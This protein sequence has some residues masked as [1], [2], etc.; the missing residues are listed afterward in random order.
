[1]REPKSGQSVSI[2][3]WCSNAVVIESQYL[4]LDTC[5]DSIT[6][7]LRKIKRGEV[8]TRNEI[9]HAYGTFIYS[10]QTF[11]HRKRRSIKTKTKIN[12]TPKKLRIIDYLCFGPIKVEI[13]LYSLRY[14]LL[15]FGA[16]L[17]QNMYFTSS[18]YGIFR[19][20]S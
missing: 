12:Y 10:L 20:F 5:N 16:I 3:L 6:E 17:F 9:L 1:M 14:R 8:Q 18:R 13:R 19:C 4:K 11:R 7:L 2:Y 15:T